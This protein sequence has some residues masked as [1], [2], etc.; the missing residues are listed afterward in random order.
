MVQISLQWVKFFVASSA[1]AV[2][3]ISSEL[4]AIAQSVPSDLPLDLAPELPDR[5]DD[6]TIPERPSDLPAPEQN[7]VPD[8]PAPSLNIPEL[9]N[10]LQEPSVSNV[11]FLV[12]QIDVVGNTVLHDEIDGL[13]SEYNNRQVTFDELLI[14]R[15]QIT[16]LY[17]DAGY[18]TSGAF[19][20]SN[21]VLNDG[22]VTIQ[23]VEGSVEEIQVGGT[24]Y[25]QRSYVRDRLAL[26][27]E[28]PL[29]QDDLLEA[30]QLLQLDP[31]ISQV[32]AEL[33][34]GTTPGQNVLLV[35]VDEP[36]PFTANIGSDNY[37]PPSIG[38]A[39]VSV[40][41]GYSNL[42]G[43]GDR[44]SGSYGRTDGLDIFNAGLSVPL[45]AREGTLSF[46]FNSS[47]SQI[48]D[49]VFED[50]EIESETRSYSLDF[51][52]PIVRS[53]QTEV[54][55]GVG[56]DLRRRQTFILDDIPFS[57][58]E[59]PEDGQSNAT[60][61]RFFQD[62]VNRGSRR[63]FAARS[64][65]SVG[66]DAFNATVNDSG[67]DARFFTWVG[68]F[69]WVQQLSSRHLVVTRIN[70][71]LT[72]DSLLS[73]EQFSIGGVDTVRGYAQNER[74]ADNGVLGSVEFRLPL[75]RNPQRLQLTPFI[76]AGKVWNNR[77]V[78][79]DPST[80]AGLGLGLRL[81]IGSNLVAR[82]DYGIPLIDVE[83]DSDSLQEDGL[84]FSLRFQPF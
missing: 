63:V 1:I 3:L 17:V 21:Q 55:L 33:T 32:N 23:I 22:T 52:Q 12:D 58:S 45:N 41:A 80:I 2:L 79:P 44:I 40:G 35:E 57:F 53:P 76:E 4:R 37:R 43:V 56:F 70:T 25:L 24:R 15:S 59:G 66:I 46:Q 69:Q 42:I 16:Q 77:T 9:D 18:V 84:Y 51:R 48:I 31:F 6:Q 11:S 49:A 50:L 30:L 14:L 64:Q 38:S 54:A 74:V 78:D 29:D 27:T 8:E 68:Q 61:I 13:I 65:F 5:I 62:W 34:A 71:Q 75:T 83:S 26:A 81:L 7:E 47:Q 60:V 72:P 10:R 73:L 39:Q 28:T 36:S 20:P 19:L 82:L 67:T